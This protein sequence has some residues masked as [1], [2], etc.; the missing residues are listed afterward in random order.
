MLAGGIVVD[1]FQCPRCHGVGCDNKKD[2]AFMEVDVNCAPSQSRLRG[3]VGDVEGDCFS[4]ILVRRHGKVHH[5][6]Q[7]PEDDLILQ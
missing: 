4:G 6:Q 2:A 3:R 5:F 1:K 7:A